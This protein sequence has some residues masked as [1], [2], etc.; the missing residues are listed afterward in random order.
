M[1]DKF[2]RVPF[3]SSGDKT[4]VTD[5][6]DSTGNVNFQEGYNSYYQLASDQGNYHPIER[7]YFNYLL[8][9]ITKVLNSLQTYPGAYP[10]IDSATNN[11][12]AY[13]YTRGAIVTYDDNRYIS[14][15]DSNTDQDPASSSNWLLLTENYLPRSGGTMTGALYLSQNASVAMGAVTYQQLT[16]A[17]SALTT[18]INN[19][20]AYAATRAAADGAYTWTLVLTDGNNSSPYNIRETYGT[21]FYRFVKKG[22]SDLDNVSGCLAIFNDASAGS[23]PEYISSSVFTFDATTGIDD[24]VHRATKGI[25]ITGTVGGNYAFTLYKLTKSA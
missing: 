15:I 3:A 10:F 21:G 16:A 2:F 11:G 22:F 6:P 13:P 25:A 8:Y 12:T 24:V 14:L 5:A 17:I 1:D 4:T 23:A 7:D 20:Q 19:V 9:S 18:A